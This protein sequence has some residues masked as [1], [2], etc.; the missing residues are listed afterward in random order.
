[1]TLRPALA[2]TTL[3]TLLALAAPALAQPASGSHS[4]SDFEVTIFTTDLA[5]GE[6]VLGALR[7]LGYTNSGNEVRGNPNE[8]FNIKWGAAPS[9]YIDQIA[10]VA[11]RLAGE[12]LNRMPIF[13]ASDKDIFINLPLKKAPA[14][15]RAGFAVTIFTSNPAAGERLMS[16]L[17]DLGYTNSGNEV[18]GNPNEDFNIK[19]GAAPEAAIEEIS[20]AASR[21]TGQTLA[22]KQIFEKT[23]KDIFINL[24]LAASVEIGT[25]GGSEGGTVDP[26]FDA[27]GIPQACGFAEGKQSFGS[28][29]KG[30]K[31]IL[32]HHRAI[33][34]KPNWNEAMDTFVGR[35]ATVLSLGGVDSAGCP[36][37][38]VDVDEKKWAWRIRDLRLPE[39]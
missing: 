31:V 34:G 11:G 27:D 38:R 25:V 32:G 35:T 13:D 19:W 37:V 28:I 12:T 18:R 2:A 1:M 22:P 21:I 33:D 36:V 8:D 20:A 15:D 24:P 23:D 30:A 4:R 39:E 17:R 7:A 29:R 9:E 5:A 10:G 6:R 3:A 14:V 16:A 26:K